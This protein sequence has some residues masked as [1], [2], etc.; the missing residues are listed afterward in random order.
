MSPSRRGISPRAHSIVPHGSSSSSAGLG[1][2][3]ASP[4]SLGFLSPHHGF[5]SH[6]G[7]GG[8]MHSHASNGGGGGGGGGVGVVAPVPP[9]DVQLG[10]LSGVGSL[11]GFFDEDYDLV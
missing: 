7:G 2:A 11:T 9:R 1:F 4:T 5:H 3:L 8:S 6:G 10:G